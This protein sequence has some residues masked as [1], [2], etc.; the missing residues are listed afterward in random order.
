MHNT[1]IYEKIFLNNDFKAI[2]M[3][4]DKEIVSGKIIDLQVDEEYTNIRTEMSGEFVNKVRDA[5]K[6]ILIDIR[7]HCFETNYYISNQAN[8]INK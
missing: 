1:Y 7:K 2:I 6:D 5:Y 8:R 3:V 4:D